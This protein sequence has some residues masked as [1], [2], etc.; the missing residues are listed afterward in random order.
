MRDIVVVGT[1]NVDVSVRAERLP[2]AGER[3]RA[4]SLLFCGGGKGLNQATAAARLGGRVHLVGRIGDDRLRDIALDSLRADGIDDTHVGTVAGVHTGTALVTVDATTGLYQIATASGANEHL[5][6]EHV[7]DAVGAFRSSAVLLVQL[8]VPLDAVEAALDLA[9]T[10]GLTTVLDP[11]P[12]RTLSDETLRKVD[13]LTPN[14][15]EAQALCGLPVH[16]VASAARAGAMLRARTQGDVVVKL[17]AQ[18]CVWVYATGFEHLPAPRVRAI[19]TTG[20][21]DA[22]DGALAVALARGES[23]GVALRE[24]VRAGA[25]ATLRRGAALG[26]PT[27]AEL[28]RLP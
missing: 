22:F 24:A 5:S 26:M 16:D 27:P 8:G 21:G 3:V 20:A 17:G 18:G 6:A 2:V 1:L 10:H 13:L 12:P 28:A 23:R 11:A 14:Q 19:D 25:A 7:R 4:E 15:H 9:R